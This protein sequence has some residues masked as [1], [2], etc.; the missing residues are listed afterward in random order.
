MEACYEPK[1]IL[2][3]RRTGFSSSRH[4]APLQASPEMERASRWLDGAD[5]G[6]RNRTRR[7]RIPRLR[8][9]QTTTLGESRSLLMEFPRPLWH[10]KRQD[11]TIEKEWSRKPMTQTDL[12]CLGVE[13]E[14]L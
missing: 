13:Q 3:L 6:E 7:R 12:P 14:T 4:R 10:L 1:V 8:G 9:P 2:P 5:V 11:R